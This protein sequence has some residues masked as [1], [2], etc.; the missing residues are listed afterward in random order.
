[1]LGVFA[2]TLNTDDKYSCHEIENLLQPI[3]MQLSKKP[4]KFHQIFIAFLK[5]TE[6]FERLKKEYDPHSLSKCKTIDCARR[7]Y[8]SSLKVLFQKT[9]RQSKW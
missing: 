4:K 9:L 2:D 5:S 3:Q 7:C 6:S 8:L 1:M